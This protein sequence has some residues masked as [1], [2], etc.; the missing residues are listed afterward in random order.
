MTGSESDIDLLVGVPDGTPQ[1]PTA[2][3][4]WNADVS[5]DYAE[6]TPSD[7]AR[8]ATTLGLIYPEILLTGRDVYAVP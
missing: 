1:R 2:R 5:V 7:L 8:S 3:H 4:I 6:K